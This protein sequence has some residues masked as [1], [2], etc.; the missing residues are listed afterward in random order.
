MW[1]NPWKINL[2][3]FIHIMA[4]WYSPHIFL[5]LHSAAF[6]MYRVTM[7]VS[8]WCK[9]LHC[10]VLT[11]SPSDGQTDSLTPS[12]H[13][14]HIANILTHDLHVNFSGYILEMRL[15]LIGVYIFTYFDKHHRIILQNDC[16]SIQY[17]MYF[18]RILVQA[19]S[20]Q[21]PHPSHHFSF[22]VI[23]VQ[24]QHDFEKEGGLL[25]L[26]CDPPG[27]KGTVHI[28]VLSLLC[29]VPSCPV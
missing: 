17:P 26:L 4:T 7:I 23:E 28:Y 15:C 14:Q 5:T 10:L 13:K 12:F 18:R 27:D 9:V 24:P 3:L 2:C 19:S 20:P 22:S 21:P 8:N 16:T 25:P 29:W 11:H 6:M 1:V